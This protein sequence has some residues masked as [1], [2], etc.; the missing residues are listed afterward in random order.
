[1]NTKASPSKDTKFGTISRSIVKEMKRLQVPGVAIG[2][3]NKG[4]EFAAGFGV[5][6][7]EHPLPVTVCGYPLPNRID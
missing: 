7:V 4:E 5:T 2:I 6:N 1:M 3:Y